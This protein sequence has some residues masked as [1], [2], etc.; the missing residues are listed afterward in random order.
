MRHFFGALAVFCA[1]MA[2]Q[3][4][5]RSCHDIDLAEQARA[6]RQVAEDQQAID[7][8]SKAGGFI[9]RSVWDGRII[10]CRRVQ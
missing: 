5:A 7:V 6:K 1:F 2:I 3:A 10:E 9:V 4:A 8:C